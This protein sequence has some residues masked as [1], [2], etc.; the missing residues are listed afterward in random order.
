MNIKPMRPIL[1]AALLAA[2]H[3]AAAQSYQQTNLVTDNQ[4]VTQAQLTDPNLKNP[5]G[6]ALSSGGGNFWISDNNAGVSTLY[7][8]DVNGSA[9]KINSL[10]VTAPGVPSGTP[11]SPTGQIFNGG[12]G[13][14]V[15]VGGSGSKSAIFITA[16]EDGTLSG[17][18]P[19]VSVTQAQLAVTT[20]GAVYK[21]LAIAGSNLYAAD[22]SQNTINVFDSSFA[23]TTLAGSFVDPYETQGFA[24]F[25]IQD[26]GG[27]LFVTYAQQNAAKHDNLD[28]V[29]SGFV[30]EFDTSGNFIQR[31]AS[32]TAAGGTVSAL[33]APWGLALAPSTFGKFG[34]DLLVGNFGSGQI[35]AFNAAT[36]TFQGVLTDAKGNP[37]V[38]SGLWGLSFGNGISAGDTN[39]LYFTAGINGEQDGLFGKVSAIP[40]AVPEASTT[41]SLGLL[42]T[43]GGLALAVQKKKSAQ[44]KQIAS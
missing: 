13:F 31:L 26:L 12:G 33:D 24:P 22:F 9:L 36:G 3:A 40:A 17:W 5:W 41:V 14:N 19:G 8:G 29:G 10:V 18:N 25:N 4:S 37:L 34:G 39:S 16:S 1:A 2:G 27:N 28:G 21:G 44:K 35:S 15:P 43:L 30:D 11:G 38:N 7:G 6:I 32:G 23:P 42:L 20:P